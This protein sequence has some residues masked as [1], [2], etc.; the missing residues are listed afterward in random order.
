MSMGIRVVGIALPAPVK[1]L[2]QKPSKVAAGDRG[3][4]PLRFL[5][6]WRAD[7]DPEVRREMVPESFS[8]Q[9]DGSTGTERHGRLM[10]SR[11]ARRGGYARGDARGQ[12]GDGGA[13][14]RRMRRTRRRALVMAAAAAVAIGAA[15]GANAAGL[16]HDAALKTV[17][18]R[19]QTR[20]K[21]SPR[22][23]VILVAV[24]NRTLSVL[25]R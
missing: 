16:L 20:G 8:E 22:Q 25:N 11:A 5:G 6:R 24:D 23:D 18:L 21:Q 9:L 3:V 4:A 10:R 19:F 7:A 17:D 14:R 13:L 12:C 1:E 15:V 2:G